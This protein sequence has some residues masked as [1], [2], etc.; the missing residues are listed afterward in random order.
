[1]ATRKKVESKFRDTSTLR[2]IAHTAVRLAFGGVKTEEAVQA[3]RAEAA[4]LDIDSLAKGEEVFGAN[5]SAGEIDDARLTTL[6]EEALAKN[7]PGK[8]LNTLY[9]AKSYNGLLRALLIEGTF[10]G[11]GKRVGVSTQ[12][13]QQWADQGYVPLKRIPEF[14]SLYGIPRKELMNPRYPEYTAMLDEPT[15]DAIDPV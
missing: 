7:A 4:K 14:E 3:I 13:V 11:I 10:S 12:A 9:A 15:F 1:M 6:I 8:L 2:A 5:I